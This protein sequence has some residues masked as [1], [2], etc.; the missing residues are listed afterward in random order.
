MSHRRITVVRDFHPRP[1]GRTEED[2]KGNATRFREQHL[3]PAMNDFDQVIVDL[4]GYNLYGSSFLEEAFG[5]LVDSAH[6]PES[7]QA[8]LR[9]VHNR[10]PS[11]VNEAWSYVHAEADALSIPK[12][13]GT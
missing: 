9:I 4:S 3:K 11:L 7:L 2:G 8:K 13:A 12:K 6:S 5:G 1:W 10:L